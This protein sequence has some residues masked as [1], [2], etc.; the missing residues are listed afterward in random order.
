MIAHP[1]FLVSTVPLHLTVDPWWDNVEVLAFGT[2]CDDIGADRY[3]GLVPDRVALVFDEEHE[4]V[5]GFV[6]NGWSELEDLEQEETEHWWDGPRFDVPA[7]GLPAASV[8]EILVA[9]RGRF[10][11]GEPTADALHFH[12]ALASESPDEALP[13]WQLA[14]EAGDMK[15]H[16]GLGY[17]LHDLGEH[18]RA[19][20]H[21][22][23]YTE[24]APANAWAWS[25]YGQACEAVGLPGEARLAYARA[26]AIDPEETDADEHLDALTD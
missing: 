8:G 2:V 3:E 26:I 20:G 25:W 24:L 7:L 12:Q 17:T 6:V 1:D 18:H 10:A 21:L 23:R 16:Y 22:R 4:E 11:D 9:I 19:Y 5:I 14:L 13:H 15:A